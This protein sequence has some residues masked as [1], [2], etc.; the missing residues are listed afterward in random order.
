M[1]YYKSVVLVLELVVD[2]DELVVDIELDVVDRVVDVESVVDV[3]ML[4]DVLVISMYFQAEPVYI[5]NLLV[6]VSKYTRPEYT[7]SPVGAE[8]P[9]SI[10]VVC[11]SNSVYR[12]LILCL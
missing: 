7:S 5:Y 2:V 11:A 12:E 9:V 3:L 6:P 10:C 4:V 8:V 1:P